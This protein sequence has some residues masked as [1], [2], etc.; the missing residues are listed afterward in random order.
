V[1]LELGRR[2]ARMRRP[3]QRQLWRGRAP[4]HR[5]VR[6]INQLDREVPAEHEV[7]LILDNYA[8]HKTPKIH[9]WLVR[10]PASTCTYSATS[11]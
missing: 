11:A 10:H 6:A 4:S 8:T 7:H 9:R 2:A 1:D 3:W 5:A